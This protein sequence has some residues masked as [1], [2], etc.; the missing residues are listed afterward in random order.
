MDARD[1]RES[2]EARE[3]LAFLDARDARDIR[4]SRE[5]REARESREAREAREAREFAINN[6]LSFAQS[7]PAEPQRQIIQV[8]PA[9][10]QPAP[11]QPAPVQVAPVQ[12]APV[13]QFQPQPQI[14][15]IQPPAQTQIF[16]MPQASP[17]VV[18]Q[19]APQP[20]QPIT[21]QPAPVQQVHVQPIQPVQSF[22]PGPRP[23][24]IEEMTIIPGLPDPNS[25]RIYHLQ[26]GSF[27]SVDSAM[28]AA[29][30]VAAAGFQ[31]GHEVSGTVH[32]IIAIGI[33][34][35][36]VR[37]AVQRLGAIGI[38]QVWIREF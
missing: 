25:G 5:A 12:P 10:V 27:S 8:Q 19:Q 20:V 2:R 26:V 18:I 3:N 35:Y 22:R 6:R 33:P 21:I 37:S 17:P 36:M 15:Q 30:Q 32:R 24:A 23:F 7:N 29:Q 28:R 16:E 14:V 4:D 34:A 38:G 9:P 31:A 13:Q 1:S 11:V